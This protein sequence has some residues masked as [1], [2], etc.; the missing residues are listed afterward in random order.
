MATT[1]GYETRR[2]PGGRSART[3]SGSATSRAARTG[4]RISAMMV[5][6]SRPT[7]QG[8]GVDR[9]GASD[10]RRRHGHSA[11]QQPAGGGEVLRRRPDA[12]ARGRSGDGLER[13]AAAQEFCPAG[14]GRRRPA[15]AVVPPSSA[16]RRRAEKP[17][18]SMPCPT[19]ARPGAS[20]GC[21]PIPTICWTI[22]RP[23]CPSAP[24]ACW[25]SISSD[26]AAAGR[27]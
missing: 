10:R 27:Q 23:W 16:S 6:A 20:R 13:V 3:A 12:T 7:C 22:G 15:V 21:W 4:A 11:L 24:T 9:P 1:P 14:G 26:C 8:R 17:G 18:P 5:P 19:T 2:Q 25:P